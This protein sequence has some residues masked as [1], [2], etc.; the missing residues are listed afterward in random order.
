MSKKEG[1]A[2]DN[3]MKKNY[4]THLVIIKA[5]ELAEAI[6]ASEAYKKNMVEEVQRMIIDCNQ[7]ISTTIRLD[8]GSVARPS[9]GCC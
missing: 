8:Y 2:V 4:A 7:T 3:T 5:R 9:S 1:L 6:I